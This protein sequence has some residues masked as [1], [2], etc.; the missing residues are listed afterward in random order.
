MATIAIAAPYLVRT[1]YGPRWAG[2]VVPLQMLCL[3]ASSG[4]SIVSAESLPR[5]SAAFTRS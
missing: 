2:V 3:V 1:V 5:V 4:L